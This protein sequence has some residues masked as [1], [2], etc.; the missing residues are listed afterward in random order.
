MIL[1]CVDGKSDITSLQVDE[2][3][4]LIAEGEKNGSS[5]KKQGVHK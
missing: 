3:V 4:E 5:L 2:R 1:I